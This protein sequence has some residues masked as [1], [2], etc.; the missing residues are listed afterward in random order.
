MDYENLTGRQFFK[1]IPTDVKENIE[2][3]QKFHKLI[4][5]SGDLRLWYLQCCREYLPVMF[6]SL[7]CTLNPQRPPSESNL[8]FILRPKQ[9]EA[10]EVL[11]DAIKKG[12]DVGIDKARKEGATEL[13]AKTYTAHALLYEN[14]NFIVGSRKKELVDRLG[15]DYTIFAKIDHVFKYLPSWWKVDISRKDMFIRIRNTGSNITGET[16]NENFSAGSRATSIFLDEFGRIEKSIA[17][18][19]EASIHDVSDCVIYGSTH[20]LGPSHPFNL[21]LQ[22]PTTRVIVLDWWHN[23]ERNQGLYIS[24]KPGEVTIY[25]VN[26]YKEKFPEL[27][28]YMRTCQKG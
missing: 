18:S 3:R 16:T 9:I 13:V 14:R 22:R 10:V 4:S 1:L 24:E 12:Y 11:D 21:A 26:Y 17:E 8:P 25:D 28:Q 7:F 27:C 19:I 15:D 20:W 6:N 2:F 5:Y 23:D